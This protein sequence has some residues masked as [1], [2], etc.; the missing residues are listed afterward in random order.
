MTQNI[1]IIGA[2]MI[3]SQVA[4]LSVAAGF[5]V[6]IGNSRGPETLQPLV[7]VL[8]TTGRKPPLRTDK[9]LGFRGAWLRQSRRCGGQSA[10]NPVTAHFFVPETAS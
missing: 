4:R 6:M 7:R 1:G 8:T 10:Q 5:K 3:G 9:F 2:G